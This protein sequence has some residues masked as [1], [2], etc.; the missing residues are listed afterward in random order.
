[1]RIYRLL[2]IS[3]LGIACAG[4][5][6]APAPSHDMALHT[7]GPTYPPEALDAKVTGSGVCQVVFNHSGHVSSAVMTKSTGTTILDEHTITYARKYWSGRPNTSASVPIEYRLAT[8]M[9]KV[10][11]VVKI[12]GRSPPY[13]S[14]ARQNR[15]EGSGIIKVSFDETGKVVSATMSKSTGSDILDKSTVKYVTDTWHV[16]IG[17][18]YTT[19]IPITYRL[20]KPYETEEAE[21]P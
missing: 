16:D 9:A 6:D 4:L 21:R 7:P 10:Q 15:I 20:Y 2:L 1:M 3:V 13:P 17:R 11:S 18:K 12:H 5:A 19:F 8:S 14:E